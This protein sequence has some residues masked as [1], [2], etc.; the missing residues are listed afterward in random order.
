[1]PKH[2]RSL[3]ALSLLLFV[4]GNVSAGEAPAARGPSLIGIDHIPTVV[5]N[6]DEAAASY[7]R[8]GF[9]LKPGRAHENGLRNRHIKF[10]DGSGVELISPPRQPSD[11]LTKT[12]AEFLRSGEGPA[13][14]SFHARDTAALSSALSQANIV[15]ETESG[16]ITLADQNL[17]FIFFVR[18]N[19]SPTDKPEHF[20]H[21]NTAVAMTEVWLALDGPSRASLR[22]LLLAL[23]AVERHEHARVPS[24]VRA[25]VFTVQNGRIV[26][27]PDKHQAQKGRRIIGAKFRVLNPQ[28][29]KRFI[30]A[31]HAPI[32]PSTAHG[33]WLRFDGQ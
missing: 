2:T 22:K 18:D 19:R 20:A 9:S 6:L 30:G 7:Q 5:E 26:V 27:V 28:A 13:Y 32:A 29:A 25:E 11:D 21:P 8:L 17:D 1:M 14:L 24:K 3:T 16:L 15:F 33:L 12:Y 4:I 10:E 23:G 31:A